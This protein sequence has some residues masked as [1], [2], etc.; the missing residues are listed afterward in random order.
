MPVSV[1][2]Y[3]KRTVAIRE[4]HT[5]ILQLEPFY[6]AKGLPIYAGDSRLFETWRWMF[7]LPCYSLPSLASGSPQEWCSHNIDLEALHFSIH[8]DTTCAGYMSFTVSVCSLAPLCYSLLPEPC[9][10][11]RRG[12]LPKRLLG[13]PRQCPGVIPIPGMT[14][15]SSS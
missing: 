10:V 6:E 8:F 12:T 11:S 15:P 7:I 5:R 2:A 14:K 13:R 3:D 4:M 9:C 1:E